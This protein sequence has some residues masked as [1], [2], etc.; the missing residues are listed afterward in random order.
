MSNT[1]IEITFADGVYSIILNRGHRLNAINIQTMVELHN[2]I[3]SLPEDAQCV[4]LEAT[5]D[6]FCAGADLE[7][8]RKGN[9]QSFQANYEESY[10]LTSLL[11]KI[12]TIHVPTLAIGKGVAIGAGVGLLLS[13]DISIVEANTKLSFSEVQIGI[14]PV[15]IVEPV[16]S[17]LP[18]SIAKMLLLTGKRCKASD[19]EKYGIFSEITDGLDELDKAKSEMISLIRSAGKSAVK[20]TKSLIGKAFEGGISSEYAAEQ[21]AQMRM[22]DDA[23]EGI[24][25]FYL[26]K[27]EGKI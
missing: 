14:V 7:W 25:G 17:A 6:V 12:K 15:A 2:A 27:H 10:L 1:N 21:I 16:L 22:T 19:L 9:N 8:L 13:C 18:L 4:V 20:Q 11:E 3:D 24:E 26:K 5:G 23:S